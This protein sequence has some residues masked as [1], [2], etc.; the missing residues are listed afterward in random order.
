[1]SAG[2]RRIAYDDHRIVPWKNGLGMTREIATGGGTASVDDWGWR[3]SMASVVQDGPFSLFPGIDRII[4]VI[5]GDGM[6][7][8]DAAGT[9][10]PLEPFEP[11]SFSGDDEW[12]GRLR[13]GPVRDLNIMTRRGRYTATAEIVSGPYEAS[14]E[15]EP[16]EVLLVQV[17][18]GGCLL[19]ADLGDAVTASEGETLISEGQGA[20]TLSLVDGE[21]CAIIRISR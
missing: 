4:A 7:L 12:T 11:V 15:T 16:G 18:A 13:N 20:F 14:L 17:L 5:E 9:I 10:L 3:L 6:D 19:C 1:M 2:F 21:R 8:T